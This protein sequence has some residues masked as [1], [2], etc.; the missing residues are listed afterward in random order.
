FR[1]TDNE[2]V[3]AYGDDKLQF[4]NPDTKGLVGEWDGEPHNVHIGQVEPVS[5]SMLANVSTGASENGHVSKAGKLHFTDLNWSADNSR[6]SDITARQWVDDEPSV[7]N[8]SVVEDV[9]SVDADDESELSLFTGSMTDGTVYR[10]KFDTSDGKVR[11]IEQ[12][13][14]VTSH[15]DDITALCHVVAKNCVISG[16]A[17]GK[18]CL[19]D[20]ETGSSLQNFSLDEGGSVS[21]FTRCPFNPNMFMVGSRQPDNKL[22]IFDIRENMGNGPKLVLQDAG[23]TITAPSNKPAWDTATGLVLAPVR[24]I[25]SDNTTATINIWEPRFVR[26]K[27]AIHFGLHSDEKEVFSVDFTDPAALKNG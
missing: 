11:M 16:T 15:N 19:N 7:K 17:S 26:C 2:T 12:Q 18:I 27:D 1:D 25:T 9:Q 13:N 21:S 23:S 10:R 6:F 22:T 3:V 4:W 5:T 24:R 14:M 8:I 20:H